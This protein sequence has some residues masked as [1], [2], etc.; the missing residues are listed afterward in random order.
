MSERL[1]TEAEIREE[2]AIKIG[3]ELG[4]KAAKSLADAVGEAVEECVSK[5]YR[6]EIVDLAHRLYKAVELLA[7]LT[8]II[9]DDRLRIEDSAAY[10]ARLT[11]VVMKSQQFLYEYKTEAPEELPKARDV[12]GILKEQPQ[13]AGVKEGE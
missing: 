1:K 8:G 11:A 13:P 6:K 3:K 4:G 2:E 12:R 7:K 9:L 5:L 10:S